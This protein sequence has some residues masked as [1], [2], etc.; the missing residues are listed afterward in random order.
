MNFSRYYRDRAQL[1]YS[2][3]LNIIN[4]E[5]YWVFKEGVSI[6]YEI[7]EIKGKVVPV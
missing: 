7:V 4:M 2:F 3:D 6:N 5:G 1:I